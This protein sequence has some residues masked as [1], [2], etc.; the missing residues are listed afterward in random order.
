MRLNR[1]RERDFRRAF[2]GRFEI[3]E[4]ERFAEGE[5]FLTPALERDLAAYGRAELTTRAV[6]WALRKRA[7]PRA[8]DLVG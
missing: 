5:G 7:S 2:E 8:G 1:W 6:R 4:E 3:L